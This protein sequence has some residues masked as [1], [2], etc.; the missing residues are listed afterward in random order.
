MPRFTTTRS[1]R[2]SEY[3]PRR[4]RIAAS[5]VNGRV[6]I[7]FSQILVPAPLIGAEQANFCRDSFA[8]ELGEGRGFDVVDDA[9]DHV[10]LA[11]DGAGDHGLS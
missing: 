5:M 1:L 9:R 7:F 8:H 3:E 6:R 2:W 4:Q 11:L 10:A